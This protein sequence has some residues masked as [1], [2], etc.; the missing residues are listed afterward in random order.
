MCLGELNVHE[1]EKRDFET[2]ASFVPSAVGVNTKQSTRREGD[3][4]M[5]STGNLGPGTRIS[6]NPPG[7]ALSG[8][9]VAHLFRSGTTEWTFHTFASIRLRLTTHLVAGLALY[10]VI[11]Q[12]L[13]IQ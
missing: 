11:H 1:R 4:V 7:Q 8:S 9:A 2:S 10:L 6:D 5:T 12:R 13:V 3:L